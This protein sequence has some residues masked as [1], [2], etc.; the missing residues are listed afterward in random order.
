[1]PSW[2]PRQP[3]VLLVHA[4]QGK[5]AGMPELRADAHYQR[6]VR[7]AGLEDE[8]TWPS[9]AIIGAVDVVRIWEPDHLPRLSAMQDFLVGDTED[10]SLWEVGTRW[11]F[12]RPVR[13]HGSLNLWRPPAE[14]HAAL[15]GELT[16]LGVPL[17]RCCA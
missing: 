7:E 5:A 6:A 10:C 16:A 17:D 2:A 3:G 12:A 11:P 1:M 9:S 13:C 14:T 8:A 4:S 15:R